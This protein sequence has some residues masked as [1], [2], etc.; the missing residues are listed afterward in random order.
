MFPSLDRARD[1]LDLWVWFPYRWA[2][3]YLPAGAE[4]RSGR[5]VGRLWSQARPELLRR[6][7]TNVRRGLPGHPDPELVARGSLISRFLDQT[8]ALSFP[9]MKEGDV[10]PWIR[11]DGLERLDAVLATGQ[12]CILAHPCQGPIGLAVMALC[13]KGLPVTRLSL[14]EDPDDAPGLAQGFLARQAQATRR[15]LEAQMPGHVVNGK[16]YLRPVLRGLQR[17][18]VVAMPYDGTPQ[19][20]EQIGRRVEVD[21][22]GHR[23]RFPVG[24]VYLAL[25]SGAPLLPLVLRPEGGGRWRVTIEAPMTLERAADLPSTLRHNAARLAAHL[26]AEVRRTPETWHFWSEFEPGRFLL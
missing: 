2:V 6:V 26:E 4:L 3:S 19:S 18:E 22:L 5:L 21:L 12:G 11:F 8:A 24:P 14:P 7:T 25:R 16:G 20:D 1:V 17:G 13:L 10:T 9:R 23:A 15:D